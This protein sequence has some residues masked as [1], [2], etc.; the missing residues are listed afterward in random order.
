MPLY[1]GRRDKNATDS[2]PQLKNPAVRP[3]LLLPKKNFADGKFS[4]CDLAPL[5]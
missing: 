4:I 2:R 1:L 5:A 3:G